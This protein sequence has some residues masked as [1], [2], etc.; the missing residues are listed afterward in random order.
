MLKKSNSVIAVICAALGNI[1]W[2]FSF[3]FTKV[4]L[5]VAP[6]PNVMLAH[7]FTLAV[8]F[9]LIPI[10]LGKEK[11]SFKGKKWGAISL[12]LLFQICYYL[13]ETYGILY[14][15]STIAGLVL[16][17]VPVVTIGTGAL[18]LREYPTKK[19]VLFCVMP[20]V[21]VIMIT[22][23]GKELGVVTFLGV[24]FL[25]LTM[26]SSAFYKTVNRKA[27]V[28]FT[29][30]ERTFLVLAISA[31]VFNISG[32]SAIK[33]DFSAYALPL[34]QPRYLLSILCLGL[35]CS[36]LANILVNYSLGKMS[37]FKVAAFG[38]LSTLCSSIAGI[39]FLKEPVSAALIVG[40]VLILIGVFLVTMPKKNKPE[41][42]VE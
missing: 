23:S 4:G 12:L 17:V 15:N 34:A 19:Q 22:I 41:Q 37:L 21:G 1:I 30:Y 26:L 39:V 6:D 16:A 35:F 42:S 29:P 7:R 2:G 31:I 9:M 14:T 5:D 8:L 18:F 11:I 3:L 32:L 28:E 20:V 27:S 40:G 24:M 36:I 38:S 25:G 33:W 13:F 10:I